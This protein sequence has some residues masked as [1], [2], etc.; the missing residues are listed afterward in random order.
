[1]ANVS[2]IVVEIR[3]RPAWKKVIRVPF[4]G[5]RHYRSFRRSGITRLRA[6]YGAWVMVGVVIGLPRRERF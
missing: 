4:L 5:W 6:V 3:Q 1:M 2:S